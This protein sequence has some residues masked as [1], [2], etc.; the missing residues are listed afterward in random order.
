M[1]ILWGK[2]LSLSSHCCCKWPQCFPL[3]RDS[4]QDD[5][6]LHPHPFILHHIPPA[7]YPQLFFPHSPPTPCFSL[8][9][10]AAE[11]TPQCWLWRGCFIYMVCLIQAS[12]RCKDNHTI[13]DRLLV[14]LKHNKHWQD[15]GSVCVCV[16]VL[17]TC[18]AGSVT[19]WTDAMSKFAHPVSRLR[20][21]WFQ[22]RH[23]RQK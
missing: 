11:M 17:H 2:G 21:S 22:A 14:S 7:F 1:Q 3:Q 6:G 5:G 18:E 19:E 20:R 8:V 9:C 15:T 16:C 12:N 23:W 13:S 10:W 4:R